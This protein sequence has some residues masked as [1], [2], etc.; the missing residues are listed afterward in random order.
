[1]NQYKL[2]VVTIS[3]NNCNGLHQ[4]LESVSSQDYPMIE[5]IVIDGLSDDGSKELLFSFIHSKEYYYTSSKDNGISDAF[6]KGLTKSCGDLILFLNSGDTL[7]SSNTVSKVIDSYSTHKWKCAVGGVVTLN[8]KGE[9]VYI[10]PT[11]SS[12]FLRFF[13][14]LP[15]QGFFCEISLHKKF[16]FD[17]SIKTSMDYDLFLRML[18]GTKIGYLDFIVSVLEPGGVSSDTAKRVSEQSCIRLVHSHN[19]LM[20]LTVRL[21]NL[22]IYLKY[23]LRIGSPFSVQSPRD[24]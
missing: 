21:I 18:K 12:Y 8:P 2:S 13:M 7:F 22:L 11:I 6:N 15:H 20:R 17:E 1:M 24:M 9:E 5:H 14:F 4:T 23:R 3:K 16:R 19:V 10:P